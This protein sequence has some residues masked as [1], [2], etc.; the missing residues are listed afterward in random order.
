MPTNKHNRISLRGVRVHNLKNVSL[1][2]PKNKFV[3]MTGLS[4]SGKSSLAF[5]T[6][7]AEGQRRYMESMSSYARQ[8]LELQDKPDV[9]E[10]LGLSPT[11]AID[12]KSSSHNPRSTVGTVTE[13][14]DF[15]RVM[16]ARAGRAHC[17]ACGRP[18]TEQSAKEIAEKILALAH[19]H[20]VILLAPMVRAQKGEQKV[21]LQAAANADYHEVRF[22]GTIVD[23]EEMIATRVDKTKPHTVEVVVAKMEK[24]TNMVLESALESVKQ[25]L[26]LGN[27]LLVALLE[28]NG[29]EF[30]FSQS[31]FCVSCNK[32]LPPLDPRLFSFNSPHG[33]CPACAGLG[34]KL[35]LEPDLVIPNKRLTLA[36]GAIKPWLRIAGNQQT[37]MRL[38]EAVGA[39][40]GFS[41][42]EPVAS[43]SKN[44]FAALLDGTGAETYTVE[45]KTM[46]FGGILAMLEEK[47]KETDSEYVQKEIEAYMRV[48]TCPACGGQ[49]LRP[50]ALAVTI[51]GK[52]IA[53][54]V[55]APLDQ[56][57]ALFRNMGRGP[58]KAK[59]SKIYRLRQEK[60]TDA[61]GFTEHERLIVD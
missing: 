57:L 53:D 17:T 30:L 54:V 19:K 5:D 43:F 31:L 22:D 15:L 29:D 4:G 56:A 37:C 38:L 12:Q 24:G 47:Y 9:D 41:V 25:A 49:R 44:M 52:T 7:H 23:V 11:I 27:G 36:Q 42:H 39:K 3:V 59:P 13:I 6:I 60:R 55:M 34:T 28:E 10:I 51:A 14:Y 40:Q 48:L 58:V 46:T 8:F 20:N 61:M 26:D 21:V 16:F 33:A 35:V 2:I 50:E 45:N 1:D 32:S 18:V